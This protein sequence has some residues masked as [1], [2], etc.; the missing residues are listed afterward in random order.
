MLHV[1]T[2]KNRQILGKK[3]NPNMQIKVEPEKLSLSHMR[4][5]LANQGPNPGKNGNTTSIYMTNAKPP[6]PI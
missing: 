3:P 6:T 5:K 4:I 1:Y 2:D